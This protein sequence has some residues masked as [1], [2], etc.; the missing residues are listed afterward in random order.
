[1][2]LNKGSIKVDGVGDLYR[3]AS[4]LAKKKIDLALIFFETAGSKTGGLIGFEMDKK[5]IGEDNLYWAE[6]VL[7]E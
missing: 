2:G 6:M 3:C 4:M 5:K 7:D 1:M